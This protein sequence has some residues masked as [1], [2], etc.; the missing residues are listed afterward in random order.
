MKSSFIS[1][2]GLSVVGIGRHHAENRLH[3]PAHRL[4]RFA[5]FVVSFGVHARVAGNL[6]VRLAMIVHAPQI[7]S[8]GHGRERA[9]ERKNF[10]AVAGKIEVANNFRPQQRHDIRANRKFE[11]GKD[12]FG[13]GR[14]AEH[15]PPFEHENFLAGARQIGG[16]D[17]AVV[18]AADDDHV[19]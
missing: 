11:A 19:V 12:L 10:Q 6:A 16:V 4:H 5:E 8:A 14:A 1:S 18:A 15:V 17:E 7:I 13:A 3:K 9:V 2:R